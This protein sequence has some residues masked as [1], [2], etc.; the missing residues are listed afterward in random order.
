MDESLFVHINEDHIWII[1]AKN[2]STGIISVDIFKKSDTS[3][4]KRFILNHIKPNNNTIITD[5]WSLI[6]F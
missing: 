5:V 1:G 6:F 3:S 2:N 4:F